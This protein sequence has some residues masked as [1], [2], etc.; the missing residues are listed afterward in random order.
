MISTPA[1]PEEIAAQSFAIIQ[2]ELA[3]RQISLNAP[4]DAVVLRLIHTSADFDYAH[5][6]QAAPGALSAGIAALKGGCTLLT[7]VEMVQAGVNR[8]RAERLGC[9]LR[10]LIDD[11]AAY[12]LAAAEG[13]TRS[14]AGVRLAAARGWL[15][16]ALIAVGNAPTALYELLAQAEAGARPAL[17]IGVPVGFVGAAES[18][19]AL[20]AQVGIPWLVT[21]GRK[22]GSA[23][24]AAAV[25]A[26][27]RLALD[28]E[29]TA[30]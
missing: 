4:L 3:A 26:L 14:A 2:A 23:V 12:E 10:C 5:I 21:V 7:D 24:A 20:M 27:L 25:N 16:G 9:G 29:V 15:T 18:K 8:G 30:I 13:I 11:P 28:E 19:A 22:G 1:H 6:T 17:V